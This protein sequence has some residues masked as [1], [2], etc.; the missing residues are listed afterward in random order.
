MVEEGRRRLGG[1]SPRGATRRHGGA[2][3]PSDDLVWFSKRVF[4]EGREKIR[5]V[6]V[7]EGVTEGGIYSSS[8]TGCERALDARLRAPG[9]GRRGGQ[10]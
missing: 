2:V 9:D 6:G 8:R 1:A 3:G 5:G 4:F 10:W 7:G